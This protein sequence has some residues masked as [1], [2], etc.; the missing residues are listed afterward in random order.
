MQLEDGHSL[1]DYDVHLNDIIQIMV[2]A[3]IIQEKP[4]ET[5]PSKSSDSQ[6]SDGR[7]DSGFASEASDSERSGGSSQN[8]V[9]MDVE[10]G[11]S[12]SGESAG[13]SGLYKVS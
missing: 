10:E 7:P 11:P 4:A 1:F 12:S 13:P 3:P 5:S 9:P 6:G 8:E 2:R